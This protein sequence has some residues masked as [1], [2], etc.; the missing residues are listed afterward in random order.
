MPDG[1]S[2]GP[3]SDGPRLE[4]VVDQLEAL[5]EG[6]QVYLDLETL[7]F[8]SVFD[9]G[10]FGHD[11]TEDQ[12]DPEDLD[13]ARFVPLPSA[14]DIHEWSMLRDF[15]ADVEDPGLRDRL[16]RAVRG[17]GAFRATK[18]LLYEHGL[19]HAWYAARQRALEEIARDWL[20]SLGAGPEGHEPP[21]G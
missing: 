7:E 10:I 15:C 13:P 19:Q 6:I 16:L 4:D 5:S 20:A 12:P 9:P 3:N 14:F 18:D 11:V 8:L 21:E 1:R 17:R 2:G